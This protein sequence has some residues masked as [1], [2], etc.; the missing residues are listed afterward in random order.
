[1]T[2]DW[3]K[4]INMDDFQ[5]LGLPS[6]SV[7][8]ILEGIGLREV[9]ITQGVNVSLLYDDVFLSVNMNDRNPLEFDDHAC[10]IDANN[11]IWLGI[12]VDE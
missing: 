1:M 9:L 8:V 11:D 3:Y 5:A 7:E 10:Y 2:Y 12:V 4:I 6:K